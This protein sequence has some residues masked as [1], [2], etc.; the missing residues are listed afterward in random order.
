MLK[1]LKNKIVALSFIG[2]IVSLAGALIYNLL[3][4]SE[5]ANGI[6]YSAKDALWVLALSP[7]LFLVGGVCFITAVLKDRNNWEG[8]LPAAGVYGFTAMFALS[9]I[10]NFA[11]GLSYF[12]SQ[13][14]LGFVA[15]YDGLIYESFSIVMIIFIVWQIVFSVL[16]AAEAVRK[17]I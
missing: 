10:F 4:V 1:A 8:T 15:P 5:L 13:Y 7:V 17:S 2:T 16:A 14:D 12:I 3:P 9:V 6:Q 11:A